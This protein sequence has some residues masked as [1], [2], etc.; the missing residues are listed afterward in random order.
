MKLQIVTTIKTI[1]FNR[2]IER[3]EENEFFQNVTFQ[4]LK[5]LRY[6]GKVTF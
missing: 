6:D 1:D 2:K 5:T 4:N 3:E